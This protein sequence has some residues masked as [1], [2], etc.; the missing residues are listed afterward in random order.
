MWDVNVSGVNI[1]NLNRES[2]H[3]DVEEGA[4]C[5]VDICKLVG[6]YLLSN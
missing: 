6:C 2:K 5:K 1:K 3:F 4:Y